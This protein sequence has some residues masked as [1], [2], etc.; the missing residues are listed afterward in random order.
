MTAQDSASSP[1]G[2]AAC[3][4]R[5]E[6]ALVIFTRYPE[7]GMVKKRLIPVLGSAGA[8]RLQREMAR[9]TVRTAMMLR[10][11]VELELHCTGGDDNAIRALFGEGLRL[12]H[13]GQGDLGAR[14]LESFH[15]TSDEGYTRTVLMGT[16]CPLVTKEIIGQAFISLEDHDLVIGPAEDGGYYLVGMK[17]P[18]REIFEGIAWGSGSVLEQTLARAWDCGLKTAFTQLLPDVDRPG[19]LPVWEAAYLRQR[20]RI[21]AIVPT[22]DEERNTRAVAERLLAGTGVEVIVVDGGSS[23]GTAAAAENSGARVVRYRPGR[24]AQM[25]EGARHAGGEILLFVHGDTMLPGGFDRDIREALKDIRTIAGAFSLS[26][27]DEGAGLRIIAHG[28]NLRSRFLQ[29]PY[30]DQGI[31]MRKGDFIARGGFPDLPIMEDAVFVRALRHEGRIVTLRRKA[32]TSARRYVAQGLAQSWLINQCVILC[33]LAG[34]AP[35]ELSRMY[36]SGCG[37]G[38]WLQLTGSVL[39][40]RLRRVLRQRLA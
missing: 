30:G 35:C 32:V 33:F 34:T 11:E 13:Q 5:A 24:A 14:M 12:R 21:S 6:K 16:D 31:F 15:R 18:C 23:D 4:E 19:D 17:H 37:A 39:A 22:L 3:P 7:P 10:P 28:A 20:P 2:R 8:A 25:N 38:D 36:R 1:T 29:L 40:R 27:G 9:H 26:F